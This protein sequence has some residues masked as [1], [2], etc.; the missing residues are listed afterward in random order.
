M[1]GRTADG[2]RAASGCPDK[3]ATRE[4]AA[5]CAFPIHGRIADFRGAARAAERLLAHPTVAVARR[6]KVNPT[7]RSGRFADAP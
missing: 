5:A 7:R 6:L 3:G 4:R 1:T 2:P